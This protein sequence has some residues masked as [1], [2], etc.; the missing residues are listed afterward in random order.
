MYGFSSL[1]IKFGVSVS[2]K[3]VLH[4]YVLACI[5]HHLHEY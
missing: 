3:S 5:G 4:A 2:A 1:I